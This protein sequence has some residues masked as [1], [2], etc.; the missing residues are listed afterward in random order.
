[1]PRDQGLADIDDAS[2]LEVIAVVM[3]NEPGVRNVSWETYR[4]RSTR[5]SG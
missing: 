1:M 3:P 4:R 5:S 2:D